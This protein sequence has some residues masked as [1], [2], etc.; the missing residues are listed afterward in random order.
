MGT[1]AGV[2][3]TLG[4]KRNIDQA[5]TTAGAGVGVGTTLGAHHGTR[6]I[7]GSTLG[8]RRSRKLLSKKT[9][10]LGVNN[11]S[12]DDSGNV[13][14]SISQSFVDIA[15]IGLRRGKGKKKR[16]QMLEHP[17]DVKRSSK[18]VYGMLLLESYNTLVHSY[19]NFLELNF[20][21]TQNSIS[22]LA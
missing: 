13:K 11:K 22:P 4:T 7:A 6:T 17:S 8:S 18:T 3:T 21:G 19:D 14:P 12:R 9:R 1:G 10:E 5:G 2:G 15:S 16:S 20:N